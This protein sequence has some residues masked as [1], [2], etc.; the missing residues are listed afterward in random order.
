MG[1]VPLLIWCS[2]VRLVFGCW[3]F[4]CWVVCVPVFGCCGCS[5]VCFGVGV[6]FADCTENLVAVFGDCGLVSR[7]CGV[8]LWLFDLCLWCFVFVGF[9]CLGGFV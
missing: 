4:P 6:L 5:L 3:K 2:L 8:S 7:I 9:S 1:F